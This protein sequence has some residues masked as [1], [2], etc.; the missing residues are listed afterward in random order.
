[1]PLRTIE[2][3]RSFA[4]MV[5]VCSL[6]CLLTTDVRGADQFAG[7]PPIGKHRPGER[8][9]KVLTSDVVT[10]VVRPKWTRVGCGSM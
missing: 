4:A 1:M 5:G 9:V 3:Y 2:Q 7:F 8:S 10:Q 6:A